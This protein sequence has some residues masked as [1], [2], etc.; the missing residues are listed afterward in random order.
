MDCNSL[1]QETDDK[2]SQ[3][4][5]KKINTYVIHFVTALLRIFKLAVVFSVYIGSNK[6]VLEI[7]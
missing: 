5:L 6:F 4:Q 1:K 7:Q 3:T 2:R